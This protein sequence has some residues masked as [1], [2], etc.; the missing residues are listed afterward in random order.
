MSIKTA[1]NNAKTHPEKWSVLLFCLGFF[2]LAHTDT[3]RYATV[4]LTYFLLVLCLMYLAGWVS[5]K[6]SDG[7]WNLTEK[8]SCK[9]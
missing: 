5:I 1:L 2:I 9:H 7:I 6:I 3:I 8:F 4:T